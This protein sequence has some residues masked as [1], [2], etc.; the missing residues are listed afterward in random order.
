[1]SDPRVSP[2]FTDNRPRIQRV[3]A[4]LVFNR[5]LPDDHFWLRLDVGAMARKV[6]PGHF[7]QVDPGMGFTVPRPLSIWNADPAQGW[8]DLLVRQVGAGTR[9]MAEWRAGRKVALHGPAGRV[10]APPLTGYSALLVAGGVGL[11][12]MDFMARRWRAA[13]VP[14]L[15]LYGCE[16]AAPL[17]L[18]TG[19]GV[20]PGLREPDGF[21]PE[22]L[23]HLETLGVPSRLT[24]LGD[25]HP[26]RHRG[27]VTDLMR[28]W[29][30]DLP[31]ERRALVRI[32]TCGPTPMMAA[33]AA[34]AA[35]FHLGG[36]ASLEEHMACGF[37]GCAGC[38]SPIRDALG[39]ESAYRRVCVDGPV[40]SLDRVDWEHM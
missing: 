9:V 33:V 34:V 38:V 1:M 37:G 20:F 19:A 31:Q 5:P 18:V 16:R 12:P 40:F 27:Y 22:A 7:V 4:P 11:A 28:H 10:F 3:L 8:I 17:P 13:G 32:Y 26:G 25:A 6:A 23:A 21:L 35:E 14:C 36:E 30:A 24:S 2:A 15:L 29:L 39:G